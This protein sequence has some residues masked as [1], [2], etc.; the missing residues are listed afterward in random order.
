MDITIVKNTILS[1]KTI[2]KVTNKITNVKQ[3]ILDLKK[4]ANKDFIQKSFLATAILATGIVFVI[5]LNT[6]FFALAL[7]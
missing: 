7:D 2:E 4:G 6:N 5:L 1:N 3:E